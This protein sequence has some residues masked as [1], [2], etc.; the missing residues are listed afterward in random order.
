MQFGFTL[1]L[2]KP[3][4]GYSAYPFNVYLFPGNEGARHGEVVLDMATAS[5]HMQHGFDFNKWIYEGLDYAPADEPAPANKLR[6]TIESSESEYDSSGDP[7]QDTSTKNGSDSEPADGMLDKGRTLFE[8]LV[9]LKVPIIGHNPLTDL[10]FLYSHF[11]GPL[12]PTLREFKTSI[13]RLF[14]AYDD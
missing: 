2:V 11:C 4:N 8:M 12:P 7:D 10:V 13:L 5:F 3:P 6:L 1:F 14:P 9:D